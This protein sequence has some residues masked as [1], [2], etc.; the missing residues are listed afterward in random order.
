MQAGLLRIVDGFGAGDTDRVVFD[1][2]VELRLLDARHFRDD[3]EIVA[4]AE[5]VDRRIGPG[6]AR[7]RFEPVALLEGVQGLLQPGQRLE[8]I[9]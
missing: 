6:A 1:V 3:H 8:R 4:L 7:A 5:H 9:G 2:D